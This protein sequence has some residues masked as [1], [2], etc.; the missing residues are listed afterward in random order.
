MKQWRRLIVAR[1]LALCAVALVL[2]AASAH[3]V[4]A[5]LQ[6]L[7]LIITYTSPTSLQVTTGGTQISSGSVIPAGSYTVIVHDDTSE[8]P[9]TGDLNPNLTISGPGV[10]LSTNLEGMGGIEDPST[11]GP[12]N[13]QTNATYNIQDANL[14]TSSLV[15]FMTAGSASSGSSS[16]PPGGTVVAGEGSS[17]SSSSPRDA[18]ATAMTGT[19]SGSISSAGKATLTYDGKSVKSLKPGTYTLKLDDH[20]AKVGLLL[21]E[22]SKHAIALETKPAIGKS[23]YRVDLTDGSWFFEASKHGPKTYFNVLG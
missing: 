11:F 14:G 22:V 10:A 17:G 2:A 20:T 19:L 21:E 18:K 15:T 1:L 16:S 4:Q 7:T 8:V 6:S 12:Y 3:P 5:H 9:N 13:L 23:S